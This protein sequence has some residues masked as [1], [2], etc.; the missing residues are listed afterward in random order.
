[1]APGCFLDTNVLLYAVSTSETKRRKRDLA[2]EL[3]QDD[4]WT[5]SIQVLQEFYVQATRVTRLDA[6]TA[7]EARLLL[8]TSPDGI[9]PVLLCALTTGMRRGEILSLDW[10]DVDLEKGVLV[11]QPEREKAGRVRPVPMVAELKAWRSAAAKAAGVP[12]Y[13]IAKDATLLAI[14]AVRPAAPDALEA[15]P[16]VGPA[17]ME[18]HAGDVLRIVGDRRLAA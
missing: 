5:L 16:G 11:V 7:A 10:S 18:R 2:R 1:M 13:V 4:D 12:A 6:L 3:L 9:R 8:S 14:A 15:I 17:F